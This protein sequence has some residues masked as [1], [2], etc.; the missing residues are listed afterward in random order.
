MMGLGFSPDIETATAGSDALK[1]TL[2]DWQ[3]RQPA[4]AA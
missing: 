4:P 1:A 2:A 3:A